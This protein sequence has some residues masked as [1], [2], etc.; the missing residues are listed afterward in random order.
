M[1]VSSLAT[2]CT[3]KNNSHFLQYREV[4][5]LNLFLFAVVIEPIAMALGRAA[6]T[7]ILVGLE[8][9]LSQGQLGFLKSSAE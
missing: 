4:M 6:A 8:L 1:F 9:P 3:S 7:P 2:L 5:P